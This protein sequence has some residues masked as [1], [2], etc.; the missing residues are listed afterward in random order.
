MKK[1]IRAIEEEV[2]ENNRKVAER[3]E[4][5]KKNGEKFIEDSH[6]GIFINYK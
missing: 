2:R 5:R 1:D 6:T 3:Y 4:E